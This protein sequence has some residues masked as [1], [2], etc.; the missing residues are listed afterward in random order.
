MQFADGSNRITGRGQENQTGTVQP[1]AAPIYDNGNNTAGNITGDLTYSYVYNAQGDVC[2]AHTASGMTG[3]IYDASGHR[4]AKGT[5]TSM[6]CDPSSN[7]FVPTNVYMLGSDGETMTEV[8]GGSWVNTHVRG[9]GEELAT[10]DNRG[11]HFQ[12]HDWLGTRRMQTNSSGVPEDYCN[13]QPFGDGENCN[14]SV[15]DATNYFFT[16]KERDTESGLDYFGARYYG[17]WPTSASPLIWV[18]HISAFEMWV[19][20]MLECGA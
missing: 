9:G 8:D 2:A 4:V 17:G 19:C 14:N 11:A 20:R 7:G 6:T 12:V 1:V 15:F 16:G 10:Y 13:S 18:P 5:I 3:Y